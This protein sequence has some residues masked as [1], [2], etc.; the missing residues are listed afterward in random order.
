MRQLPK[1][2][3]TEWGA[4]NVPRILVVDDDPLLRGTIVRIL[5]RDTYQVTEAGTGGEG[6]ALYRREPVD[7]VIIDAY[8]PS[9]NG[10]AAVS[11]LVEEFP[12]IKI[13]AVSAGGLFNNATTV[14]Q[15]AAALGAGW[16][17]AKP[18]HRQKLLEVV[19]EALSA[20]NRPESSRRCTVAS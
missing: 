20:Q 14:L 16:T 13:L 18:F 7:L 3:T 1:L 17:L 4:S 2:D 15:R 9:M 10:L 8:M 5:E 6:V 11:V 12:D 19:G